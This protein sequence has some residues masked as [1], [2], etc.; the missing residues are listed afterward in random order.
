MSENITILKS[1]A[2]KLAN[3]RFKVPVNE[4]IAFFKGG[5]YGYDRVDGE[6]L[7]VTNESVFADSVAT[8][9]AYIRSAFKDPHIFLKKEEIIQNVAVASHIDN[10]TLR[11]N[12][13]DSK[14]W[15]LKTLDASPEF[16]HAFVYEDDLAIYENRF[17]TYLIDT[18]FELLTRRLNAMKVGMATLAQDEDGKKKVLTRGAFMQMQKQ[19]SQPISLITCEDSKVTIFNSFL[20]S[21]KRLTQLKQHPIYMACKKKGEFNILNLHPT[22]ILIADKQYHY[23]YDFYLNYLKREADVMS[24]EKMYQTFV[25]MHFL[26]A[27]DKL[28]FVAKGQE[29][30]LGQ[31]GQVKFDGVTMQKG[32][33]SVTLNRNTDDEVY[34][35]V[36]NT[37]SGSVA[38]YT[39]DIF[40]SSQLS[41]YTSLSARVDIAKMNN[42]K[43][44]RT[45]L[46][47][48]YQSTDDDVVQLL[49]A[50]ADATDVMAEIVQ[51]FMVCLEG[52]T[53]AYSRVCP[54]CGGTLVAQVDVDHVCSSCD[55]LY[56]LYEHDKKQW[57]WIKRFAN[58]ETAEESQ[59]EETPVVESA[60]AVEEQEKAEEKKK[61]RLGIVRRKR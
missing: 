3:C 53:E 48:D 57:L 18:L 35:K 50:R 40:H 43:S 9:I 20:K 8:V 30:L 61:F 59:Q 5:Q 49:P 39:V 36:V 55:G 60:E 58:A 42:P 19:S 23:C 41:S 4:L 47:T 10:E 1:F 15:K 22:N 56:N 37:V 54:L 13:K 25:A 17:L 45:V 33:F 46:V 26:F 29:V 32:A 24:E 12:Y 2:R 38:E 44:F 52:S 34:C 7:V 51:S 28:G 27:L 16:V 31:F 14:L 11:M 6:E 21:R